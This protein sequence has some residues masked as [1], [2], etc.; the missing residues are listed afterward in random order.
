MAFLLKR[1]AVKVRR[2]PRL[3][4]PPETGILSFY[5]KNLTLRQIF[6]ASK[7]NERERERERETKQYHAF[8]RMREREI[9]RER[10]KTIP[11]LKKL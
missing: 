6:I 4:D 7:M 11:C 10:N 9:A 3:S 5:N 8:K 2:R 1:A